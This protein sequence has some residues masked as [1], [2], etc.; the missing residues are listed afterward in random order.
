MIKVNYVKIINFQM[1]QLLWDG[2]SN[3]QIQTSI[4]DDGLNVNQLR[5]ENG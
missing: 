2:G 5:Q 1:C 3:K 4:I